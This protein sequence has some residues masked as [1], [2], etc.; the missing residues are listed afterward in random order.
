MYDIGDSMEV[1]SDRFF[2]NLMV[3]RKYTRTTA[4]GRSLILLA[5]VMPL[6][7]SAYPA[8]ALTHCIDDV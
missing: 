5:D 4:F 3:G 1:I 2:D 7:F 6:F 8:I